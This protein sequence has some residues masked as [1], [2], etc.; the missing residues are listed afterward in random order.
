MKFY[1]IIEAMRARWLEREELERAA[2]CN[3]PPARDAPAHPGW[4]SGAAPVPARQVGGDFYN[5]RV[6]VRHVVLSLG[7]VTGKGMGAGMLAAATR[8]ALRATDPELSPA[9][10]S[11]MAGVGDHDLHRTS[12]F[13]TLT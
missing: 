4:T 13:I 12:A 11:R 3:V 8:A 2:E 5:I 10:A 6:Q 1:E 7:D 9:A